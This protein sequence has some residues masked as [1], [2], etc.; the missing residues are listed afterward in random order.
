LFFPRTAKGNVFNIF[1]V[2]TLDIYILYLFNFEEVL[3]NF[4]EV[5]CYG[6]FIFACCGIELE[7]GKSK[8]ITFILGLKTFEKN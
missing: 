6:V 1:N 7:F 3:I 4:G 2:F 5:E 8:V